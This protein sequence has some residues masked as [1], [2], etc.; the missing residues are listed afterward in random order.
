MNAVLPLVLA[1][2]AGLALG[3]GL[4]PAT[5]TLTAAAA[6]VPA[7]QVPAVQV[8]A[9]QVPAEAAPRVFKAPVGLLFSEVKPE[10]AADFETI[11]T[12]LQEAMAHSTDPVVRRQAAGWHVFKARQPGPAKGVLYV[13]L[14][15]PTVP[16]ADYTMSRLLKQLFP[17]DQ[18]ML[19][20]YGEAFAGAQTLLD[21]DPVPAPPA[22]QKPGRR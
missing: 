10:K 5:R 3:L 6:Q 11:L 22:A 7:V 16:A 13:C 20:T 9:A 12:R 2:C 1:G 15:D 8:P 18:E 14:V 17:D 4:A 21:L 19:A